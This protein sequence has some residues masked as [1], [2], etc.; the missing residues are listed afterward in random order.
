MK[1][2]KDFSDEQLTRILGEAVG[3][4]PSKEETL[5]AWD[6]FESKHAQEITPNSFAP[7]TSKPASKAKVLGMIVTTITMA[8]ALLAFFFHPSRDVEAPSTSTISLYQAKSSPNKVEQT[9]RDGRCFVST[10]TS[11]TTLV[12]LEDG[13][14]ITLNANSTLEYPQHFGRSGTREVRLN[15]EAYFEVTKNP[16]RPFV[17]RTGEMSTQVL[18]TIFD[19]K[20]Y[21]ADRP[22]V[23]LLEGKVKVSNAYT[24]TDIMPGQVATLQADK[25]IISKGDPTNTTDWLNDNFEMEQ[26]SLAE[27]MSDIG[28]W[29]NKNVIIKSKKNM[30]KQLHFRFSR[31]ASVEEVIAALNDMK[32]AHFKMSNGNIVVE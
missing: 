24:S 18:G 29:Y 13:T 22:K 6:A 26:A 25:I 1:E 23:M 4:I 28:A 30:N 10:P 14:K 12:T 20:A 9:I 27:A 3:D 19:V 11:S 17:V 16:H 7:T 2:I 5:A 31:K 32:I 21:Q 15:G 8:A